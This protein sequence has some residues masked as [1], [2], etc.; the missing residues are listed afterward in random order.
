M[1]RICL[2]KSP[3][4]VLENDCSKYVPVGSNC[5]TGAELCKTSWYLVNFQACI[6]IITK[7]NDVLRASKHISCR[8]ACHEVTSLG[9][10]SQNGTLYWATAFLSYCSLQCKA[11]HI[12]TKKPT[13][14]NHGL[15]FLAGNVWTYALMKVAVLGLP[16][17]HDE[18]SKLWQSAG[19]C[20]PGNMN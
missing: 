12:K 8:P 1:L 4:Y 15:E 5:V 13:V 6:N 7:F 9:S 14:I 10:Q 17:H 18:C 2:Y 20:W 16:D 19:N 11:T 3:N